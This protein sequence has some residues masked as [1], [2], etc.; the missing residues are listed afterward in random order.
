MQHRMYLFGDR[1]IDPKPPRQ[2]ERSVGGAYALC[3]LAAQAGNDCGQVAPAAQ[4]K[5]DEPVAPRAPRAGE[6]QVAYAGEPG[7]RLLAAA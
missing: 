7:K 3:Y 5:A 1:H 2:A 6:H 4:L